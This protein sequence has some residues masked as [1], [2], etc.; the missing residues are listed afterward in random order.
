MVQHKLNEFFFFS[1]VGDE[2][3]THPLRLLPWTKMLPPPRDGGGPIHYKP[4]PGKIR[5]LLVPFVDTDVKMTYCKLKM[6]PVPDGSPRPD[7]GGA[8]GGDRP[9]EERT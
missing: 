1:V 4:R 7:V 3:Y 8:P 9:V 2:G 6:R 5:V